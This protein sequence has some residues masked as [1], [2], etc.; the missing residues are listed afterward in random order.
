MSDCPTCER[1]GAPAPIRTAI[2]EPITMEEHYYHLC[3]DCQ[4]R[5]CRIMD[6]FIKGEDE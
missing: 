5:L 1:C 6:L 3:P 4:F 2:I